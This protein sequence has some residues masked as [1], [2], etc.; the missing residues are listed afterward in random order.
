MAQGG[1]DSRFVGNELAADFRNAHLAIAQFNIFAFAQ[2]DQQFSF[3][4][5]LQW[6]TWGSGLLGKTR[7]SLAFLNWSAANSPFSF[8]IGRFMMPFGL[9]PRRQLAADN[10][11][12]QAPL[13]YGYFIN[14]SETHGLWPL[15]GNT[16]VYGTDDVGITTV[17]LG[18]YST[19]GMISLSLIPDIMNLDIAMTNGALASPA[20]YTNL[21]NFGLVGRFSFQPLIF[22]QQGISAGYGSFMQKSLYNQGWSNLERFNQKIFGTDLV[23]G[24]SYFELSGEIAYSIWNVPAYTQLQYVLES[25]GNLAEFELKNYGAYLDLKYEPPFITG[26]YLAVS[27]D[28]LNFEKFGHPPA[29]PVVLMNPWDHNVTRYSVAIGYKI[30]RNILFKLSYMDQQIKNL[31]PDPDDF[32]ARAIITASF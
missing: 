24:Y 7:L 26:S 30:S 6:D 21:A 14:I 4:A 28:I 31:D 23:I 2:I 3:N 16:G 18:G 32:A 19:G 1:R 13:L 5:R 20:E 29:S 22:W 12:G 25:S 9:Y 11:F 27:Y 10:L 17:Y 15:A 8:S